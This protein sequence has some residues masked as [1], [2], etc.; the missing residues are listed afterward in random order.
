MRRG[1]RAACWWSCGSRRPSGS[2]SSP[3]GWC[4]PA[5]TNCACRRDE[6]MTD[7][8]DPGARPFSAFRFALEVKL[9]DDVE[10]VCGG[11]FPGIDGLE[12]SQELK[13]IRASGR[14][15]GPI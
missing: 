3:S 11:T 10:R 5:A 13:T 8:R 6:D 2:V 14:K 7:Q 4:K 9:G 1:T 15:P 12:M